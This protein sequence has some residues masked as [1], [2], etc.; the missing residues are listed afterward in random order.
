MKKLVCFLFGFWIFQTVIA[1]TSTSLSFGVPKIF[2]DY[3]G[4]IDGLRTVNRNG[5][6]FNLSHEKINENGLI[7]GMELGVNRYTN[8]FQFGRVSYGIKEIHN[9]SILP[10]L[11]FGNLTRG[12]KLGIK[13]KIAF[14]IGWNNQENLKYIDDHSFQA[15][16]TAYN[17]PLYDITFSGTQTVN[18]RIFPLLK[19]NLEL[20]YSVGKSSSI[21]LR[22][23]L[24]FTF[25]KDVIERDFPEVIY[26]GETYHAN[27]TTSL[28]YSSLELGYSIRWKN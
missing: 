24:A 23:V 26:E 11:G 12:G 25:I 19:P 21:F 18:H 27:H 15:S 9:F 2:W 22:G 3:S 16:R 1:Q 6:S 5:W 28:S 13:G 4:D 8:R 7:L 14:G 10:F 20:H 17:E